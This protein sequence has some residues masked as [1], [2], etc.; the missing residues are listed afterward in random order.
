MN[1]PKVPL[2]R[3]ILRDKDRVFQNNIFFIKKCRN[4]KKRHGFY[5]R[6]VAQRIVV[7]DEGTL[8]NSTIWTSMG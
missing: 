3:I 8:V 2:I 4:T 7:V 5:V 1:N 6:P